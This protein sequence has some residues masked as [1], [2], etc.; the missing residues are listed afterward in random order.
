M[1]RR[2]K[3]GGKASNARAR[4]ATEPR[5][6]KTAKAKRLIT[7]AANPHKRRSVLDLTQELNEARER[8]TATADI[9]K[10]IASSPS[11]AQPVFEAIVNSATKLIGGFTSTVHRFIGDALH[12]VAFTST[13]A[14]ADAAL[15]ATFPRPLTDF[16]VMELVRNG[17][18]IE[19]TDTETKD[20][21]QVNRELARV[22][23]YRSMLF[24]PLMSNGA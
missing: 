5:D 14:A 23:G 3:T 8:Q 9:L 17:E 10:V 4:R 16:P 2:S 11:D 7:P 15:K 13:N 19:F 20:V 21:P 22:R 6:R 24:T 12:L 18:T 1:A